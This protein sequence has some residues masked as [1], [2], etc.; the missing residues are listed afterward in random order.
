MIF[1]G[2]DLHGGKW[3]R[4]RVG[5]RWSTWIWPLVLLGS[6]SHLHQ[7]FKLGC[8]RWSHPCVATS[9]L[10]GVWLNYAG[11]WTQAGGSGGLWG[12]TV[13]ESGGRP[14]GHW[15]PG[16]TQLPVYSATP[17]L[18]L[19][20]GY[21]SPGIPT[22]FLVF[23]LHA[24]KSE[25]RQQQPPW[26]R[27]GHPCGSPPAGDT[28]NDSH[29][30]QS[31]LSKRKDAFTLLADKMVYSNHVTSLKTKEY[32]KET[33]KT[34]EIIQKQRWEQSPSTTTFPDITRA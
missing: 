23:D 32:I 14:S 29:P 11:C 16:F 1:F 24:Q 17:V 9:K 28:W 13:G 8:R 30:P 25:A 7:W 33:M 3:A 22:V 6:P 20:G 27:H 5:H 19:F 10:A 18:A 21:P 31:V 4:R 26:P 15:P 12:G 34:H 2:W